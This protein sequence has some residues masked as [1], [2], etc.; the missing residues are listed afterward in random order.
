MNESGVNPPMGEQKQNF[1]VVGIGASA[2][3]LRALEEFF[4]HMPT[5]SGAAFVVV[6]HLSPDFKSLMKE[7]LERRTHIA[8]HRVTEGMELAANSIYLIPPGKN[9]V[10]E[11]QKLHLSEQEERNRHGLNFPIDIFLESLAKTYEE[12]AI[13]V[14]LSGTGSDGT[15][16]IRAINEAGGFVMVQ[17][18]ESA[19][20][21]GMPRTAM[22]TGVVD[23]VL[24]PSELAETINNL[25]RLPNLP[26]K[27]SKEENKV[28][29]SQNLQSITRILAQHEQTDFSHYKTNT[30]S[31]R[32]QRRYLI[33]GCQD[34]DEFMGLLESSA[35]ER[36]ILCHDLLISVT[37]F[38]RDR[39]PWK[40]LETRV[41]PQLIAKTNPQEEIRCW[42]TACATGEEA[43]SLAI[44]LDEAVNRANKPIKFRIFAT[45]IDKSALEKA[46]QGIYSHTITNDINPERLERYFFRKENSWQ[47]IRKLR[48]KILFAPHDLTKDAGFTRMNLISCRNVLIYLQSNL[49]QQV[50]RNLHFSLA[51]KGILFLGEAEA[52]GYIEPEFKNLDTRGKIYQKLRDVRLN[53]PFKGVE[54]ITHPITPQIHLKNSQKNSI[55]PML[56][57]AFGNFL[58]K[59]KATCF[60]VD[61]EYRLFHTSNHNSNLLTIPKGKIT[62]D[63]TKMIIPELQ[64]PLITALHR[65]KRERTTISYLGIKVKLEEQ[66]RNL[67]LEVNYSES[68]KLA[69]DFFTVTIQDDETPSQASGEQFEADAEASQRIMELEYELQQTRENLQ[70]VIE[71]LETTNEEQQATNEELTASNEEL[72]STNEELHSV[73][74]ELYTVN[75]EYQSKIGELTELNNDID[76]LLRSTDIGVVFLDRDLKIRKF[77]PA[78]AVAINLVE[79]DINRPLEHITHNLDCTNLIELFKQVIASQK[80]LNQEVK[81]VKDDF[82]LLMR[83]NPYLLEDG[84][85][86][87]IVVSFIDID[88]L[89]IIQ[90]QIHLVNEE[91]KESQSQLRQ[92]NRQLEQRVEERAQALQKSEASLRAILETTTSIIYLKDLEGRYLLA[93]RQFLEFFN[94]TEADI[95]GKS[96]FDIFPQQIAEVLVENDHQV[97]ASKSVLKFEEPVTM[98]NGNLRTYISIKAP[99]ISESNDV[100]A[101]CGISTDISEQKETE[102][103][104]RESAA[105][106]RTILDVVDNIRQSL[107]LE[108]IFQVTTEKLRETIKCDRIALFQF[109]V[110][111]SGQ[112]VAESMAV[113]CSSLKEISWQDTYL[114]ETRGGRYREHQA[115]AIENIE[116]AGFSDCHRQ[117]YEKLQLK[118]FC[119]TPVFQNERL[120]GLLAAYQNEQPRVWKEGEIRLLTQTGI[121][122]GI[123]IAQVDLFSQIQNQ[124]LQLQQ[125]KEAAEA[126]NQAKSAFITHTSH[127]LRTPL[128]SILGFAQIL[129]KEEGFNPEQLRQIEL[130]QSSGQ[131]LLTLINDI[132]HI[133]KIEA[134]KIDLEV[135][136]F[137]LPSF[138]ENLSAMIQIRCQQKGIEFER[139]LLSDLPSVV[140]GDATRLRQ[141]LLNLL[142]NAVKFTTQGK[143]TF[144][145]G[146]I[147]DY[148]QYQSNTPRTE[149][150]DKIRFHIAD[151]GMGIPED[152]L[153]EI[154]LPFQ[155]LHSARSSQEG[156]GLGLSISQSIVEQMDSKIKVKST[157][158]QGSEFWFDIYLLPV[159]AENQISILPTNDYDLNFT[160]YEGTKRRILV[161]DDSENN[162]EVLANL[163][164]PLGFEVITASSGTEGITKTKEGQPDLIIVD[165]IMSEMDGLATTKILRQEHGQD[166]PIIIFSASNLPANE[167]QCYEAGANAFLSKPVNFE[168]LLQLLEQHLNLKWIY[169]DSSNLSPLGSTDTSPTSTSM[170]LPTIAELNQLLELVAKGDIREILS[171]IDVWRETQPQLAPF[172]KQIR[173]LAKSFQLKR[174]KQLVKENL[175][176]SA[177]N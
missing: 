44:L 71:E 31:R 57:S 39:S 15:N 132:L 147:R 158:G 38:F 105:R 83:I 141:L 90:Q 23:R 33:S 93:N 177:Q 3:G 111:W 46:T 125:A 134:G 133:A 126:A 9:L 122:L 88:E 156:T 47:V 26:N 140:R 10:L 56:E 65:A 22:A 119:I 172:I 112:F 64:L 91:L 74:E 69:D 171:L 169:Q 101:I 110:D 145:V 6:Q 159:E 1:F 62:T 157:L 161:I 154:F 143:V 153:T 27:E 118:A 45:D 131:H 138:L 63:I 87:G 130:I 35:E 167:S 135:N 58:T 77:T 129:Q 13:G 115:F 72:Q 29:N 163:L 80:V 12:R 43:Y 136:D 173:T 104:L 84:S 121:Q 82:H 137:V 98:P 144:S 170:V 79:A 123:S 175:Q 18:P 127:E 150:V 85:L 40:F 4:E 107:N 164:T 152:K 20:F 70:S 17:E 96:D 162:L 149:Q 113:G 68:N 117:I 76:N 99:L 160:S 2:G 142:S 103:E 102:T 25:V 36:E 81:V 54:R 21:D 165:L 75:A 166:L 30:L 49:Q 60:L 124:T 61:R 55:E 146:Y 155:Q 176:D 52:L 89:K 86:D 106:E 148:P 139:L 94:L 37:K 168:Q 151:T 8:V 73:N 108:E 48:E 120:W 174:L 19:E 28:L 100:Y 53:N 92:L 7:L 14:I 32:I 78:A 42:V 114:Q 41:I 5:D 116:K 59:Y 66:E 51:S 34:I 67:K 109:N 95:L 16:G 50:L 128:N 24:S 11:K 97:L